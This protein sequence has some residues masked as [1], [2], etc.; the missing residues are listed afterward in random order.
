MEAAMF[1]EHRRQE[2]LWTCKD[3]QLVYLCTW[4]SNEGPDCGKGI[5]TAGSCYINS[6]KQ[7]HWKTLVLKTKGWAAVH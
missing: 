1:A 4:I 5:L 2:R 7:M 6:S 3:G